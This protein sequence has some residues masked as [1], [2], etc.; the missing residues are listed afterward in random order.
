MNPALDPTRGSPLARWRALIGAPAAAAA[1][2]VAAGPAGAINRC[3]ARDGRVTYTDEPCPAGA[4]SARKVD[5]SPP[6]RLREPPARGKAAKEAQAGAGAEAKA[7][8][9]VKAVAAPPLT[10]TRPAGSASPEQEIA[11][12][13]E[14]R[15]RQQ[16][17]CAQARRRAEFAANDLQAAGGSDRASAE[18]ALRRAQEEVRTV[19]PPQ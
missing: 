17:Q 16:H 2:L 13:D 18:L 9:P 19:C 8:E 6:L 7:A 10:P 3:E 15:A 14:L 5:D 11:R 12:L 4:R 1:L